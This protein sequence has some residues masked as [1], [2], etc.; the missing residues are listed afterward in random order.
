MRGRLFIYWA[1]LLLLPFSCSKEMEQEQEP[2]QQAMS[3]SSVEGRPVTIEFDV[4]G[5]GP[6]T[7]ALGEGG[8]LHSLHLAVFGGSGYLKEYV[9]AT[10]VRIADYTYD[11]EDKDGNLV[12]RTVP[13]YRFSVTLTL[14]ESR[15]TVHL[16]GNGPSVLPFGYDTAVMP[17]LLSAAGEMSY[18]QVIDLPDGI[19]AKRNAQ[20]EFID[21]DGKV[22][23]EGGTGYIADDATKKKFQGIPLIRNWSKIVLTAEEGS[24]F[25]PVSFAVVNTPSRGTIAPYSAATE[26][27]QKYQL[28]SFTWLEDTVQYPGN[29]PVGTAFDTTIPDA[30]DFYGPA[31]GEGVSVAGEGAVYLYERPAPNSS[32]PPSYVIIYGLY[33]N[34]SDPDHSGNYYFYKVDL[35]ETKKQDTEWNSRYYPIYRNFKYQITVRKIL[36]PGQTTPA[37]AAVSAGSADVSADINTSQLADISDGVGRL[38]I[39][40][41]MAKTFTGQQ[42]TPVS[43]LHVFFSQSTDG[44]P[45]MEPNSVTVKLLTPEDGGSDII[46]N[47][48]IEPPSQE[49]GSKGWRAIHFTTVAPGRT[50]RTQAIRVTGTHEYGRLYRDII[51]TIQPIQPMLVTCDQP[52]IAP[53]KGESE[54]ISIHIPDG[55]VESMFPLVFTIEAEKMSLTPNKRAANNNLPVVYG[56]SISNTE[57][58]AGKQAFQFERTLPWEEYLR[59]SRSEDEEGHVW[60]TLTCYFKTNCDNN[61]SR[62]WVSNPYFDKTSDYFINYVYKIFRNFHFTTPI[63]EISDSVLPVTFEMVEEEGGTYPDD[64]PVITIRPFGMRMDLDNEDITPGDE[65]GT[66]LYKPTGHTVTLNFISTTPYAEEIMLELDANE[67]TR[68]QIQALRFPYAA[69]EDGQYL[70]KDNKMSNVMWGHVNQATGWKTVLLAYMDDPRKINTPVTFRLTNLAK[71]GATAT[72]T[73]TFTPDGPRSA[74]G[75]PCYHEVDLVEKQELADVEVVMESPGYVT[76]TLRAGRF[77]GDIRTI[78]MD[79][80]VFTSITRDSPVFSKIGDGSTDKGLV[81]GTFSSVSGD[82]LAYVSLAA[83]GEYTLTLTGATNNNPRKALPVFY[84]HFTFG[85]DNNKVVMLPESLEPSVGTIHKYLGSDNQYIWNIPREN[86]EAGDNSGYSTVSV[87]IKAPADHDVRISKLVVK[88]FDPGTDKTAGLYENGVKIP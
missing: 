8:E 44:E 37:A 36:A 66:Y 39:T 23:P 56:E 54:D 82:G 79:N 3:A 13:C 70:T 11:M 63:P 16:L 30:E 53:E 60:R 26:F 24:N 50:V 4:P 34:P 1:I 42:V 59:L 85:A 86:E 87:T 19:R 7:K 14:S 31:F 52:R 21:A 18:W 32:I 61:A 49:E 71:Y 68:G 81:Q 33:D 27:I 40:D 22:I 78:V 25:T 41:W 55:L 64:Y 67:Y 5:F 17:S 28:C 88:I 43:D 83:G 62:V 10:P 57:G 73:F 35:M 80:N 84:V 72:T 15:R 51:V 58:F 77:K 48:T 46:E 20:G 38:H 69:L 2:L 65:N 6:A 75:D 76:K 29:L 12:P 47:L 74:N 9:E 45:D